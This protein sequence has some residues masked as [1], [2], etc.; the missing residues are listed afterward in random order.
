MII[1]LFVLL[2]IH[3]VIYMKLLY[4]LFVRYK[5]IY[6]LLQMEIMKDVHT[7]NKVVYLDLACITKTS[8]NLRPEH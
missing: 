5:I 1:L 8:Y 6:I 4:T 2:F 3:E 7:F